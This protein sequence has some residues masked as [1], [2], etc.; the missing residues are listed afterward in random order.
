M[1]ILP[2][3]LNPLQMTCSIECYANKCCRFCLETKSDEF[4]TRSGQIFIHVASIHS[5]PSPFWRYKT[6]RYR[7][8]PLYLPTRGSLPTAPT[9]QQPIDLQSHPNP[10]LSYPELP[11]LRHGSEAFTSRLWPL[12]ALCLC[13]WQ[14]LGSV[15]TRH[16]LP[17]ACWWAF[18]PSQHV[19]LSLC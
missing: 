16:L 12:S 11:G 3:I 5:C 2:S 17:V 1:F 7:A 18:S 9:P 19:L 8:G 14:A 10:V 4:R 6:C 15:T 13:Q